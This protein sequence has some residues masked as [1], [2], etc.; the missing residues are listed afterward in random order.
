MSGN[1]IGYN[2]KV[3]ITNCIKNEL[4]L[5]NYLKQNIIILGVV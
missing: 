3:A 4:L 1:W 5:N 2:Y